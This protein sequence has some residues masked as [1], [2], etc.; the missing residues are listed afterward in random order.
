VE[1][2]CYSAYKTPSSARTIVDGHPVCRRVGSRFSFALLLIRRP[3]PGCVF[4]VSDLRSALPHSH[5]VAAPFWRMKPS[6]RS[7]GLQYASTMQR[8]LYRRC[9]RRPSRLMGA[10]HFFLFGASDRPARMSRIC[11]WCAASERGRGLGRAHRH[12]A[13]QALAGLR[14]S[15]FC[16][17]H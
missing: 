3:A 4:D 17:K 8:S 16:V 1:S 2:H 13:V 5:A 9:G 6:T 11:S 7:S 15:L 10:R 14:S 12:G